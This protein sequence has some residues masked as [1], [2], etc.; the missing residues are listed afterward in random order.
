VRG[1]GYVRV[2]ASGRERV[3]ENTGVKI[4]SFPCLC[5]P[6]GEEDPLCRSK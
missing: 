1:M 2:W 5:V 3:L 6:R 4:F